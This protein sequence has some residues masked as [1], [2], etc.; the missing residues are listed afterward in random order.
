MV[1]SG[2]GSA[3]SS[4]VLLCA[5]R[6]QVS[7]GNTQQHSAAACGLRDVG[8]SIRRWEPPS[9]M[10]IPDMA[11]LGTLPVG[12]WPTLLKE[13]QSTVRINGVI[14]GGGQLHGA[15]F[16]LCRRDVRHGAGAGG[17][18]H[19]RAGCHQ[20][21]AVAM[22]CRL[23][24]HLCAAAGW[25]LGSPAMLGVLFFPGRLHRCFSFIPPQ[26]TPLPLLFWCLSPRET[27]LAQMLFPPE[28]QKLPPPPFSFLFWVHG[29]VSHDKTSTNPCTKCFAFLLKGR[30]LL[31]GWCLGPSCHHS[32]VEWKDGQS[33]DGRK[34]KAD[35]ICEGSSP[36]QDM[37]P[38]GRK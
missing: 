19:M 32:E 20:Q 30:V 24:M 26:H 16:W 2:A 28:R 10:G 33:S 31:Q 6:L 15:D 7:V 8:I 17:C 5:R 37:M 36:G 22:A 1:I 13:S 34:D 21:H 4:W 35:S 9:Y 18:P 12:S 27:K 29:N 25:R 3:F 14:T 23:P 11:L 38:G